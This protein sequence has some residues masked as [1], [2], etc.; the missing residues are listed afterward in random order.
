MMKAIQVKYLPVTETKPSRWKAWCY[1]G[2]SVTRSYDYAL[3]ED[4]N[5]R[6]V[7]QLLIDKMEHHSRKPPRI[8]GAG[9]LPNGDYVFTLEG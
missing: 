1:G 5:A 2:L 4:D 6:R 8:A 3:N 7:A 9:C